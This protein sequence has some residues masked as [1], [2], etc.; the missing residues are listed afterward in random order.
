LRESEQTGKPCLGRKAVIRD[1]RGEELPILFSSQAVPDE[2]GELLCGIEVFR[3]ATE[4]LNLEAHKRNLIS[5]FAHDL[6]SPVA[7]T[8]GF[9]DRL[10]QGK[11]GELNEKQTEYLQTIQ[12][13]IKRLEQYIFS[14]LDIARIESGQIK[15]QPAPCD[16]AELLREIV[17][18]FEVQALAKN[19]DLQLDIAAVTGPVPVDRLQISRVISNLLD[20]AIKYSP[21]NSMVLVRVLEHDDKR[22]VLEIR[23]QGPGISPRDQAHIFDHFYRID[24]NRRTAKGTGLGL[25]AVK[26]IVEAH[27][28]RVRLESMPGKG[29]SFIVSLPNKPVDDGC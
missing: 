22:F 7:I 18:G 29:S 28:G 6:K 27:G 14:F 16:M 5:L 8:G 3:D 21:D 2:N 1:S 10:L 4:A 9:V 20:N 26:A 15:L 12:K 24:D 23:D 25:A 11:A 19:I 13:E 17:A